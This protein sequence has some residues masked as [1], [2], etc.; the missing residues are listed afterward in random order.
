[1]RRAAKR[2]GNEP[3]IIQALKDYGFVVEQV[4]DPG[5]PDLVV[6]KGIN[7]LFE[8]KT[9]QGTLT[10]AQK[11]FFAVWQGQVNVIRT[12]NDLRQVLFSLYLIHEYICTCGHR[13]LVTQIST[14]SPYDVT[15]PACQKIMLYK[16]IAGY[17]HV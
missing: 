17:L 13:E 16:K 1:M 2:D 8:I 6:S 3:E 11:K 10:S 14:E 15:C 4:S 12:I 9:K 5:L 7:L